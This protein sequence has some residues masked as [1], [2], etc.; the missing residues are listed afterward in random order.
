MSIDFHI[1]ADRG[2][3]YV[4]YEGF[5]LIDD[6]MKAFGRYMQHP[7]ARP[8]QK[9]FVDLSGVTG[10]ERDFT[11]LMAIQARKADQFGS[12][13]TQTLMVYYAPS[14]LGLEL[15][16]LVLR[17]WEGFDAVV[18]LIQQSEQEA[19]SLLGL[20]ETCVADLLENTGRNRPD[21]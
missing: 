7:Q 10:Y 2:L 12:G 21:S 14:R 11:R 18:A 17:S 3:V 19:L 9:Q 20:P 8:G 15:A 5:A 16:Q 1:L 13:G 4:R 6:T